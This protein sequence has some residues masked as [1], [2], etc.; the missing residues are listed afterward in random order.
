MVLRFRPSAEELRAIEVW[1]TYS[2]LKAGYEP[3]YSS[4][5]L[6]ITLVKIAKYKPQILPIT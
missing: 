6:A 3:I 5:L 4:T 2:A 1:Q